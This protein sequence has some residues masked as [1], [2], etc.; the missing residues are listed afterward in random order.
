MIGE[1]SRKALERA[2]AN[3][4]RLIEDEFNP[5]MVCVQAY[6]PLLRFIHD[7]WKTVP[8]RLDLPWH[9][10][11]SDLQSLHIRN[12]G[13]PCEWLDPKNGSLLW[14]DF[15]LDRVFYDEFL[16]S[17]Q[18]LS[19]TLANRSFER[20]FIQ[21]Y[22]N[23]VQTPKASIN[24]SWKDIRLTL[25]NTLNGIQP[26]RWPSL[27]GDLP[28]YLTPCGIT[29]DGWFD[30]VF[31]IALKGFPGCPVQLSYLH[32]LDE[33]LRRQTDWNPFEHPF[34]WDDPEPF[35]GW[36][37][38]ISNFATASINAIDWLIANW[39]NETSAVQP[40]TSPKP[41]TKKTR[42]SIEESN[43]I[44][45]ELAETT[46]GKCFKLTIK[47]VA[48]KIGCSTGIVGKLP[49][50]IVAKDKGKVPKKKRKGTSVRASSVDPQK[51]DRF[52]SEANQNVDDED[53]II[54]ECRTGSGD[55][56]WQKYERRQRQEASRESRRTRKPSDS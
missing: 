6:E 32:P 51:M 46:N 44:L 21:Y 40:S 10:A 48:Q 52:S 29:S 23:G 8:V 3:I 17:I 24:N 47:E 50:W 15:K 25:M 4:Q 5:E 31:Q 49:L 27:W 12:F 19:L 18:G 30:L 35:P 54:T 7:P 22:H 16:G 20:H 56:D 53:A 33:N 26:S 39:P 11:S 13:R 2:Q 36:E 34:R 45:T 42:Q 38:R 37:F 9:L 41:A 28:E 55:V 14:V 43:R 1:V